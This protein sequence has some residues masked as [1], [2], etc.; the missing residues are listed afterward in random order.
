MYSLVVE[1]LPIMFVAC[2]PVD[3]IA[4]VL[5]R[6]SLLLRHCQKTLTVLPIVMLVNVYHVL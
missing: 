3:I 2:V 4:V 1:E 6:L 5:M